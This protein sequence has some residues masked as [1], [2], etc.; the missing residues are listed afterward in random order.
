MSYIIF[1]TFSIVFSLLI[2]GLFLKFARTLGSKNDTPSDEIRW[3]STT[4]PAFGGISF[5]IV[6]LM[7]FATY[8]IM[9][10]TEEINTSFFGVLIAAS[11]GFLVGLADDAYNTK[12]IL[13]FLGQFA[14]AVV[15]ILSGNYINLFSNDILNYVITF[16][17]IVGMMNSINMLDNMDGITTSVSIG[18]L[19]TALFVLVLTEQFHELYFWVILGTIGSLVGFLYYN[20]NPSKMYM[21]DTGSQFLG[22]VLAAVGIHFFWNGYQVNDP[23]NSWGKFL[24]PLL[25]FLPSLVD[26]TTVTINRISRGQSPFV[27]GR[28]HTTHHLSFLG[29]KDRHIAI[30]FLSLTFICGAIALYINYELKEWSL[31]VLISTIIFMTVIFGGLFGIT[32]RKS[33]NE[34]K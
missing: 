10:A 27:G 16:V 6:F 13:K 17:W 26:T 28:D 34:S 33:A 15:L 2:N 8:A 7:S 32:K 3:S 18:T 23:L 11:I 24:T 21:G 20:W 25:V 22:V 4:K 9:F 5:Y 1:F 31:L 14:C 30:F 29:L 19:S 12:P